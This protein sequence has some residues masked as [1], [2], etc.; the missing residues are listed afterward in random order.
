MSFGTKG[1]MYCEGICNK[2]CLPKQETL[3]EVAIN[4]KCINT[5]YNAYSFIKGAEWQ[6]ERSYSDEEVKY[7]ISEALQSAL[8]K[9]DLEQWFK[10]F[11]KK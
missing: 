10:Q 4:H 2:D 6:Q 8:V 7:I 5:S 11:K 9:V 3:E 1:C